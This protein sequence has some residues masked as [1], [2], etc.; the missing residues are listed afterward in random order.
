[1]RARLEDHLD[2]ADDLTHMNQPAR[3]IA[4]I[5]THLVRA[6][7]IEISRGD[8][9]GCE[10]LQVIAVQRV[11]LRDTDVGAIDEYAMIL[12]AHSVTGHTH[13]AFEKTLSLLQMHQLSAIEAI[14]NEVSARE[15]RRRI[16]PDHGVGETAGPI[17][18]EVVL[19][20]APDE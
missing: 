18:E 7:N 14:D 2:L 6:L 15:G 12:N 19:R 9:T 5:K 8:D 4:R 10:R 11:L 16:E 3:A 17:E 1:M 13:D 20:S